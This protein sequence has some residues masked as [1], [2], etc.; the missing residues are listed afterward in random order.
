MD[1]GQSHVLFYNLNRWHRQCNRAVMQ[2]LLIRYDS[3]SP[4][5]SYD[6]GLR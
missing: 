4:V 1:A 3:I 5:F 6:T 2:S